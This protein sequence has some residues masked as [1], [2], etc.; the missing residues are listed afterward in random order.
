MSKLTEVTA[1]LEIRNRELKN[2][3]GLHRRVQRTNE[4]MGLAIHN[5]LEM[6]RDD[7]GARVLDAI[8]ELEGVDE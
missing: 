5:A 1:A 3:E 7:E 8:D 4:K 6:L 2:V